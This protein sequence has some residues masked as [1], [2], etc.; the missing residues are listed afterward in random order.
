MKL[1]TFPTPRGDEHIGA[2]LEDAVMLA[3]ITTFD[4]APAFR[5]MLALID[6]GNAALARARAIAAAP[7][8]S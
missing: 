2:L 8:A 3:D 6:G 5:D 4:P 1:V 7:R